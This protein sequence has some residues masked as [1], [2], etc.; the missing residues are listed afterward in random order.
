LTTI[1]AGGRRVARRATA[2]SVVLLAAASVLVPVTASAAPV[3]K[4]P[5]SCGV[6]WHASTRS[7]H[8]GVDFN[9]LVDRSDGGKPVLASAA[10]TA[11]IR[12][13]HQYGYY[14]D[15]DHGGGWMTR[16]AHLA[17]I[18]AITDRDPA[19]SGIQVR[20]GDRIGSVG[21]TGTS[22]APHLHYEQRY[23][24]SVVPV[25]FDGRTIAVGTTYTAS[26]PTH[27]STNCVLPAGSSFQP[28]TGDWNG[29]GRTDIG[30]RRVSTGMFYLR[31]GPDWE[32]QFVDWGSG[33]GP[34][35]QPVTGDWDGDGRTDIGLRRVSTGEFYFRTRATGWGL[36]SVPWP[37]GAG[38]DL[39]PI[40]GDW[41][42]D[43]GTDIGLRRVSTGTFFLRT[44]ASGWATTSVAWSSGA[45]TDLQAITGDWDGDHRADIG[46]RRISTGMFYFRTRSTGWG[47]TSL[48][49]SAGGGKDLQ[50]LTGDWNGDVRSDVGLRRVSTGMF[51]FRTRATGW[52][53]TSLSWSAGKG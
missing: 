41:D 19:R 49:W 28:I 48:S 36:T 32:T 27:T 3:F 4:A 18:P 25:T 6:S 46:L 33:A 20:V 24:G 45:G 1:T 22:T 12:S 37:A 21:S 31:T 7:G 8:T 2:L 39:Q 14:V 51:Y 15:V 50:P 5:W 26:D 13:H 10:G 16:Q 35:L 29:D 23:N 9:D 53:Q 40:T 38:K 47:Q 11:T 44:R 17:S 42:G 34:D 43:G 30:L 52:G